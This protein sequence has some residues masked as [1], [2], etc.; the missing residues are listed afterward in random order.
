MSV[1]QHYWHS[2]RITVIPFVLLSFLLY[3]C[4]SFRIIVIPSL[5]VAF[6]LNIVIPSKLLPFQI[7]FILNSSKSF[8]YPKGEKNGQL[9]WPYMQMIF[10]L[11][12]TFW[13]FCI[14][15]FMNKIVFIRSMC[16][17]RKEDR[18]PTV[19][20]AKLTVLEQPAD[21]K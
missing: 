5:L 2:F 16:S 14:F 13:I 21:P 9:W 19:M 17:G 18:R 20:K 10:E 1:L 4:H 6:L 3:Y 12:K 15:T 8:P 11:I 7:F